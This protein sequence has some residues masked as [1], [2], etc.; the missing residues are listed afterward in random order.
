MDATVN[1]LV[2]LLEELT[3]P[4][5]LEMLLMPLSF[6]CAC[7]YLYM[8]HGIFG[9]SNHSF[10]RTYCPTMCYLVLVFDML[11][12][13]DPRIDTWLSLPVR[14]FGWIK[15]QI[16]LQERATKWWRWRKKTS[17]VLPVQSPRPNMKK[18][19]SRSEST[20]SNYSRASSTGSNC[21]SG[22]SSPPSSGQSSS[23]PSLSRPGIAQ[24]SVKQPIL[25]DAGSPMPRPDL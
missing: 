16:P 2:L 22:Y 1:D 3:D 12:L 5:F 9:D 7:I 23:R 20:G 8:S 19:L 14:S 11:W 18:Q 15:S 17:M 6:V 21:S 4:L 13:V 25:Y 10:W 24:R